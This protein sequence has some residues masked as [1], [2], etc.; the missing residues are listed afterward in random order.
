MQDLFLATNPV[1]LGLIG[2]N[3]VA[4]LSLFGSVVSQRGTLNRLEQA[5]SNA[6]PA[7]PEGGVAGF[8]NP[9]I[10]EEAPVGSVELELVEV[11]QS[12]ETKPDVVV[13]S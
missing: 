2:I 8:L 7:L 13:F 10:E 4:L 12:D 1:L 5:L 6:Q 11:I 9:V 3:T